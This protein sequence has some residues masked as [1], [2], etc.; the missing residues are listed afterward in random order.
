MS[1]PAAWKETAIIVNAF[2]QGLLPKSMAQSYPRL[3]LEKVYGAIAFYLANRSEID[4]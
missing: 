3:E 4:D 1:P 2:R